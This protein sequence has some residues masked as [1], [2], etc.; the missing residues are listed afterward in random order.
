MFDNY[1]DFEIDDDFD[2]MFALE[3]YHTV[4]SDREE[5]ITEIDRSCR[6]KYSG[7][8]FIS[9]SSKF[10]RYG[11]NCN[12]K[13]CQFLHTGFQHLCPFRF[14]AKCEILNCKEKH[15]ETLFPMFSMDILQTINSFLPNRRPNYLFPNCVSVKARNKKVKH[16]RKAYFEEYDLFLNDESDGFVSL[17]CKICSRDHEPCE[18]PKCIAEWRLI[19]KIFFEKKYASKYKHHFLNRKECLFSDCVRT[20]KNCWSRITCLKRAM[21]A[22]IQE[23]IHKNP[24]KLLY[25]E[26]NIVNMFENGMKNLISFTQNQHIQD[27]V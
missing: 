1:S 10:C 20:S 13:Q 17:R 27:V 25:S 14:H 24:P 7:P 5:S 26:E 8:G 11:S 15:F 23:L 18:N 3:E 12:Y 9:Y 2:E 6:S 4:N 22:W 21:K 19:I 16:Y